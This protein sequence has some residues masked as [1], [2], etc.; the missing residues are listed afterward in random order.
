M[1][2]F[3][4]T[5]LA[6]V[7]T[8]SASAANFTLTANGVAVN[9]GDRINLTQSW[10]ENDLLGYFEASPKLVLKANVA[11]TAYVYVQNLKNNSKFTASGDAANIEVTSCAFG[12]CSPAMVGGPEIQKDG[13]VTAGTTVDLETE[14]RFTPSNDTL[15]PDDITFDS[16]FVVECELAGETLKVYCYLD[17]TTAGVDGIATDENSQVVYYD[18]QGRRVASP[19]KGIYLMRQGS[20]TTKVIF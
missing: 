13:V 4:M 12:G 18:L 19:D 17:G 1:K 11:G 9:D 16:E 14:F 3:Y 8:L 5:L 15:S 20:K 10:E 7:A 2:K 6:L